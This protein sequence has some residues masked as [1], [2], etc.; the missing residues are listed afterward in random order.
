MPKFKV[1]AKRITDIET[2]IE[3][4]DQDEAAE[5]AS[6]LDPRDRQWNDSGNDELDVISPV[7]DVT[8]L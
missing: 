7:S 6:E 1:Y 2:I 3:A 8:P 4:A 5:L